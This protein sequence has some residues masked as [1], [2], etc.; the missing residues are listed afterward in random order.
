MHSLRKLAVALLIG[1]LPASASAQAAAPLADPAVAEVPHPALWRVAD[2]DTVIYLFGTVHALPNDVDWYRGQV[3]VAL[4]SALELVTELGEPQGAEFREAVSRHALM[5]RGKAL[6][7]LLGEGERKR[8]EAALGRLGMPASALDQMKPWFAGITIT[9]TALQKEGIGGKQGVET[10]ITRR[11]E[12][13]GQ[14]H[15]ALETVDYQFAQFDSLADDA[16]L[17]YLMEVVDNLD[18]LSPGLLKI[19]AAWQAGQA[20]E[21]ARLINEE[22]SDPALANVL[23]Y[24]RNRNWADWIRTRM[25]QP[26]IAFVAVGAGHLAGPG[27]VQDELSARGI[28]SSRIQ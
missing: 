22:Q 11:A 20:D 17:R 5:P 23:L 15:L 13:L 16:E 24:P 14:R 26:G 9:M 21:L 3:A 10:F 12:K 4:E 8:Y 28:A 25:E 2:D 18:E 27:S 19:I 7:D 6:R 1:L